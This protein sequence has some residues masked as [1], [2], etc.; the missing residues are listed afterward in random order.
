MVVMEGTA[1]PPRVDD[2]YSELGLAQRGIMSHFLRNLV[3]QASRTRDTKDGGM[4]VILKDQPILAG[5]TLREIRILYLGDNGGIVNLLHHPLNPGRNDLPVLR[6][7]QC[8]GYR[9][10]KEGGGGVTKKGYDGRA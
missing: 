1:R 5:R 2:R 6:I 3:E 7:L 8:R 10:A 9:H 4:D